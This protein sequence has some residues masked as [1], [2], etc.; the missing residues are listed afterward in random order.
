MIP[1][2]VVLLAAGSLAGAQTGAA[3]HIRAGAF[4]EADAAPARLREDFR[5][6]AASGPARQTAASG[7]RFDEAYA[8]RRI[9][10]TYR[11]RPTG[12]IEMPTTVSGLWLDN[13]VEVPADYR[14]SRKW[15]VRVSLH[16]GVGRSAPRPGDPPARAL[17]NRIPGAGEIVIHPRSWASAEW[18]RWEQV[19]NVLRLLDRVK[20][21]YN[22][23]ESR[24]Y[25][26]GISDGGTG[27]YFFGMRAA[28]PWAACLPLNGHPS[29]LANPDTGADGEL[30]AA[31]LSN[32]PLYIVNGGRDPLYPASSVLPLVEMLRHGGVPLVFHVHPDA[33]HDVSWWPQERP[34]YEAFLAEHA[35]AAHPAQI[36]WETDRT[37]RY[38]R[39]RWLVIDRLGRR[40]SDVALGDVNAFEPAAGGRRFQLYR[41]VRDSG[42]ADAVRQGNAFE[43]KT[44]GVR[45]LTLLLSPDAIDFARPVR[46]TV[47][48]RVV[49]DAIVQKDVATLLEWADRDNDRTMLYGAALKVTVP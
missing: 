6:N 38:N 26:T 36:S 24:V 12:R 29:V 30:Y 49:H 34:R 20:R 14:P 28:T 25:V 2:V 7:A 33:G 10:S 18:W 9:G 48:G 35:R 41:R 32:C 44:R 27:V 19:E 4:V 11:M 3:D 43:L 42:R 21:E 13:I 37:D 1:A 31:N 22:V 15:P 46:V 47:N 8:Q 17:T 16:G 40:P 39:F 45:E 23:D 5:G